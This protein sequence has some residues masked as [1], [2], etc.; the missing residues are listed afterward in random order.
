MSYLPHLN[1]LFPTLESIRVYYNFLL[2]LYSSQAAA[3]AKTSSNV[4]IFAY[5]K[6]YQV[7]FTGINF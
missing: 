2:E 1:S 6:L 7:L 5:A 3:D 4:S